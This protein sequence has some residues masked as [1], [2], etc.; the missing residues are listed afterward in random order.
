MTGQKGEKDLRILVVEDHPLQQKVIGVLLNS[1]GYQTD[2][3]MDG[4]EAISKATSAIY[5]VI[6]MDIGLPDDGPDGIAATRILREKGIT[7]PVIALTAHI[8]ERSKQIC[9]N[10][11]FDN[12]MEKPLDLAKLK[13]VIDGVQSLVV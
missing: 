6:L 1:A 13:S 9:L 4:N 8:G 3:A 11:G 10:A 2:Y 5:D 7:V 12:F